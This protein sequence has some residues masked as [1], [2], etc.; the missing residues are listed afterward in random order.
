MGIDVERRGLVAIVTVDQP[1]K[2]NALDSDRLGALH[3]AFREI[4]GDAAVRCVV[5]TGGGQRAFI[6]GADISAMATMSPDEALAF[7]RLGHAVTSE[8]ETLAQP[9]IA[10]VNG[11]AL[12]GGCELALACDIRVASET[13]VFAQPEVGLGIPPGWGGTQR[14]PRLVGTGVAAELIYTGRRI[15][16]AEAL[17]IGLVNAV[18]PAA[19]LMD[20]ALTM[21]N[22]IAVNGPKAVQVSKRLIGMSSAANPSSGLATEARLFADGFGSVEQRDGMTAFLEKRKP[23]FASE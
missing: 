17:R 18:Y 16:A 2:L 11:F 22:Q 21:A 3:A 12:G 1:D 4:D 20:R 10:A 9:V 15:D 5:L 23:S 7:A 19:E 14:L 8:I 13:A 6:A